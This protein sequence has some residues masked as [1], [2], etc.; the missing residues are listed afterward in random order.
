[1]AELKSFVLDFASITKNIRKS[2]S[3]HNNFQGVH[4]GKCLLTCLFM[5][6]E[7]RDA[8]VVTIEK[9]KKKKKTLGCY[10]FSLTLL[11]VKKK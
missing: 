6:T 10:Y 8:R 1:M 4:F 2:I 3:I 5:I 7:Y 9:K 11:F